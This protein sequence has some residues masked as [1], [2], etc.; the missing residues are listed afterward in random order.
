MRLS[1]RN[2]FLRPIILLPLPEIPFF[3]VGAP[4]SGTTLLR[5]ILSS[6]PRL[7]VPSETGFVPYLAPYA[8]KELK[9]K[10]VNAI[11]KKIRKHNREWAGIADQAAQKLL[12]SLSAP[13][14]SHLLDRLYRQRISDQGAQRWGDKTPAYLRYIPQVHQIFPSAQFIHIIRDGRD[15]S[16]SAM[17]KWGNH[18]WYM[19]SYYLLSNWVDYIQKGRDASE[20][21]G[22]SLYLEIRYEELVTDPEGMARMLC[23]FLKEEFHPAMLDHTR[24]AREQIGQ[25]GHVEVRRGINT[26]SIQRWK[27]EMPI[28]DQ[29]LA[30]HIAGHAL[31][32]LGY[33][34]CNPGTF[35][36]WERARLLGLAFKFQLVNLARKTLSSLGYLHINRGKRRP[37]PGQMQ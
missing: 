27:L 36:P 23:G 3:I 15:A 32:E 8:N 35:T 29:K 30:Y 31:Q 17:E 2:Q 9:V 37:Q 24:L 5:F 6:H 22:P 10:N 4:R 21:L 13:R 16:L 33:E 20:M 12:G 26:R 18:T 1:L 28:F 11:L 34:R 25:H 14:L 19:D 7:Y